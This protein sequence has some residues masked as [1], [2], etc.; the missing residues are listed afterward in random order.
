[1]TTTC[2]HCVGVAIVR[3]LPRKEVGGVDECV[4]WL[5][6]LSGLTVLV[7]YGTINIILHLRR[8]AMILTEFDSEINSIINP[9]DC[10]SKVENMPKIGVTC[11][12][13]KLIDK[14]I[15]DYDSEIVASTKTA[16]GSQPVYKIVY[17]GIEIAVFMSRVGGAAC[18]VTYEEITE[19]GVEKLVMFGTCGVLKKE[20][21][22]LAII[23]PTSAFRD[24]GTSYHYMKASAEIDVN[25][26]YK[27]SFIDVLKEYNYSYICGKT[28]T[29]D[30]PYRETKA[31]VAKRR[32]DGAVCVDMECAS[33]AA[34][35]QF[36]NKELFQFFY[37]ADNLDSAK[38]DQRSLGCS[39]NLTR[40]QQIVLLAFE[41]AVKMSD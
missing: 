28:W 30:A 1:M 14:I 23:I 15:E 36:R 37:A 10:V 5:C 20:I 19:M 31:K 38:W 12:S 29:T 34:V 6:Q 18:T 40:K 16:N 24:E 25:Q 32:E 27:D 22:D 33:M 26:K 2:N 39:E 17:K 11:F 9:C 21:A 13:K 41:M 4:L 35:S 3:S 7:M 8:K